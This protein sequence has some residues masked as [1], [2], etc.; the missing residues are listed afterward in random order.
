MPEDADLRSPPSDAGDA[1][2]GSAEPC[3]G[4]PDTSPC[5]AKL[6][7]PRVPLPTAGTPGPLAAALRCLQLADE[8]IH[9]AEAVALEK[10]REERLAQEALTMAAK[11]LAE[12]EGHLRR[13]RAMCPTAKETERRAQTLRRIRRDRSA[14]AGEVGRLQGALDASTAAL[15]AEGAAEDEARIAV[16]QQPAD[17][18]VHVCDTLSRDAWR[19]LGWRER[20]TACR[21]AEPALRALQDA[22]SKCQQGELQGELALGGATRELDRAKRELQQAQELA[23]VRLQQLEQARRRMQQEEMRAERAERRADIQALHEEPRPSWEELGA[24]RRETHRW[25]RAA[26]RAGAPPG[27]SRGLLLLAACASQR[28]WL[29][30]ILMLEAEVE[31]EEVDAQ[32]ESAPESGSA[33]VAGLRR[34]LAAER[35]R[36]RAFLTELNRLRT[37]AV[38]RSG[39]SSRGEESS[40]DVAQ[41]RRDRDEAGARAE[42]AEQCAEDLRSALEAAAGDERE[43]RLVAALRKSA[44]AKRSTDTALAETRERARQVFDTLRLR[45]DAERERAEQLLLQLDAERAERGTLQAELEVL[46]R[47]A[48][49][50]VEALDRQTQT[51]AGGWQSPEEQEQQ[52]AELMA[53]ESRLRQTISVEAGTAVVGC[54]PPPG[55]TGGHFPEWAYEPGSVLPQE[56]AQRDEEGSAPRRVQV[57]LRADF[58]IVYT[59]TIAG[60]GDGE[61]LTDAH[62]VGDVLDRFAA[63][64]NR[65]VGAD[66]ASGALAL[67]ITQ[68]DLEA[69]REWIADG[70]ENAASTLWS[71]RRRQEPTRRRRR[72]HGD[73]YADDQLAADGLPAEFAHSRRQIR[74]VAL[75]EQE[76]YHL[77]DEIWLWFT[78]RTADHPLY[79]NPATSEPESEWVLQRRL[80]VFRLG[81]TGEADDGED[82][83]AAGEDASPSQSPRAADSPN[84][85]GALLAKRVAKRFAEQHRADRHVSIEA[86]AVQSPVTRF[87]RT[88]TLC[89]S[90]GSPT[91]RRGPKRTTTTGWRGG[92]RRGTVYGEDEATRRRRTIHRRASQSPAAFGRRPT[93]VLTPGSP[94]WT[95]ITPRSRYPSKEH[96]W[97]S[98]RRVAR[99]NTVDA[100]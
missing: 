90:P 23:E 10:S 26:Q 32:P 40:T 69:M 80:R 94:S 51:A 29:P 33:V 11:K 25:Q 99:H 71:P 19:A 54:P 15:D 24:M 55:V 77:D 5:D 9:E 63:L 75:V 35:E 64:H 1:A 42:A 53:E 78:V 65:R 43:Q 66:V 95:G 84:L 89:S 4:G 83:S 50:G 76:F 27:R 38:M 52:R 39:G 48:R 49:I 36:S 22:E 31:P 41:L 68:A 57:T 97:S 44:A 12:Q 30:Q 2:S 18:R 86:D 62:T 7:K 56:L 96:Q 87:Q 59:T 98:P 82:G 46:R 37:D 85:R 93:S 34:E 81:T 3:G 45:R 70:S 14:L 17:I 21:V 20:L 8:R 47:A 16:L 13:L 91:G 67:R 92:G 73:A 60:L 6:G 79:A 74:S 61:D 88:D 58:G 72:H 28:R 100:E